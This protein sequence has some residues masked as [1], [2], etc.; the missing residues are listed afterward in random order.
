MSFLGR[1]IQTASG[2]LD[3]RGAMPLKRARCATKAISNVAYI[4]GEQG[5]TLV[6][7]S[8]GWQTPC[9]TA[10]LPRRPMQPDTDPNRC[11]TLTSIRVDS[12]QTTGNGQGFARRRPVGNNS[13]HVDKQLRLPMG[14]TR[15]A[16]QSW[17][18]LRKL[19]GRIQL[20]LVGQIFQAEACGGR[21]VPRYCEALLGMQI[22]AY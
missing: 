2:T 13:V 15:S 19:R 6:V 16:R 7:H 18:Q 17:A 5:G 20:Q 8:V 3:G 14:I 4:S 12:V 22:L 10:A 1:L 21:P 9:T 11:R